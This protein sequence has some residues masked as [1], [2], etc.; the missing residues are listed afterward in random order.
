MSAL[1]EPTETDDT[2]GARTS[3]DSVLEVH[4]AATAHD[5][6]RG[7]CRAQ[8]IGETAFMGEVVGFDTQIIVVAVHD[9]PPAAFLQITVGTEAMLAIG[10]RGRV[11]KGMRAAVATTLTDARGRSCVAF[12]LHDETTKITRNVDRI[13][14]HGRVD[15]MMI[16]GRGKIDA[17]SKLTAFNLSKRGMGVLSEREIARNSHLL[18]RFQVPQ[19]RS[20]T[21]QVR[22]VVMYCQE[23]GEKLFQIGLQ[24][25]RMGAAQT[26]LVGRALEVLATLEREAAQ[27]Q[28]EENAAKAI[29]G[30]PNS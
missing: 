2:A 10:L 8:I 21:V 13:A 19:N 20:A 5:E 11:A 18:L 28:A 14:F 4:R 9:L 16:D 25:E 1:S 3:D 6:N 26:Q 17:G 23:V 30:A 15:A 29:E 24:F 7:W 22:A 27:Q 12:E